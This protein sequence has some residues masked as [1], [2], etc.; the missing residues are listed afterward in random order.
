MNATPAIPAPVS[1]LRLRGCRR[2]ARAAGIL[3]LGTLL[4]ACA[5]GGD[6][7][8]LARQQRVA[9]DPAAML[10]IAQAAAGAGEW[11]SAETFYR[12]VMHLRPDDAQAQVGYARALAEQGRVDEAIASLRQARESQPGNVEINLVLGR[13]L[14]YA[15]RPLEALAL[16]D[17]ALAR[18]PS[19]AELLVGRGVALDLL[20]RHA[21]A[22]AA[23]RQ[24]LSLDRGNLAARKNLMLSSALNGAP[25]E[26][27]EH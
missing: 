9:D 25:P 5:T 10:R 11:T 12:R 2:L 26:R 4:A 24:A 7:G 18:A 21:E 15:G 22:Q 27:S 23:Y 8:R 13:L 3:L 16:F 20:D 1:R 19:S 17:A 6:G 14:A